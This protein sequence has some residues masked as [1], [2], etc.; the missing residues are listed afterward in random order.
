[1]VIA[2]T[3]VCPCVTLSLLVISFMTQ[4]DQGLA[5]P[6]LAPEGQ[7]QGPDLAV[8]APARGG[9]P[10]LLPGQGLGHLVDHELYDELLVFILV[11]TDAG[12][13]WEGKDDKVLE[14]LERGM[15]GSWPGNKL[16]FERH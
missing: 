4:H 13:A 8:G 10:L 2:A 5:C 3:H 15:T 12:S 7:S 11:V 9:I 1:M 16:W 6:H 14:K